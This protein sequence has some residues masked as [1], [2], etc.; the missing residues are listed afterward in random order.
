MT[1]VREKWTPK[2]RTMVD[3]IDSPSPSCLK[4]SHFFVCKIAANIYPMMEQMFPGKDKPF[5]PDEIAK[6]CTLYEHKLD[7]EEDEQ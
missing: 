2:G 7:E 4:C 3:E 5:K 1:Y 6:L